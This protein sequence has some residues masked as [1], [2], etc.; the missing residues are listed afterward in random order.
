MTMKVRALFIAA[1][2][3][4]STM[5]LT[6]CGHYTCG[7][8]F[9][10]SSC[11]GGG[12]GF[13]NGGGGTT[14]GTYLLIADAG[15]IQGEVLDAGKGTIKTNPAFG[16]TQVTT[17]NTQGD[18]MVIAGGKFMYTAYSTVG[19]IYGFTVNA[20][21]TITA[22]S[23]STFSAVS[24]INNASAGT[25][26]MIADPAGTML[27][28]ADPLNEQVDVYQ[29]GATGALTAP[30]F[31]Q[32]PAGF[33][34]FNFAIDGKGKYLYVS[35][36][37]GQVTTEVAVYSISNGTLTPVGTAPLPLALQQMQGEASG[38]YM[39][40]TRADF[41]DQNLYAMSIDAGGGLTQVGVAPTTDVPGFVAVQP[42]AGG[43]LVYSFGFAGTIEGA[44]LN[45]TSGALIAASGSPFAGPGV[46]GQF[47]PSGKFLFVEETTDNPTVLD[48]YDVSADSNLGSPVA[49]VGWSP[50][51]WQ[52]FDTQ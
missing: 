44:T 11:S 2:V 12:G 27:F 3:M 9:G 24:L 18:W 19:T 43:N 33:R 47:N 26:A 4:L 39:I 8:T 52:A 22:L 41:A 16:G 40:G 42:N 36:L 45:L 30:T 1:I 17:V 29:I 35:N 7:Q 10:S 15:G 13:D 28:L 6:G 46:F 20:N 51:A 34:P 25:Q 31:I 23:P 50:G 37:V 48:A 32:L 49:N 21:G 5:W 14:A 38:K